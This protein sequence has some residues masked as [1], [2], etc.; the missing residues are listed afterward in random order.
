MRV[1]LICVAAIAHMGLYI[2]S[3]AMGQDDSLMVGEVKVF[4]IPFDIKSILNGSDAVVNGT[5]TLIMTGMAPGRTNLIVLGSKDERI[6]Y[7]I[8]ISVDNR[9][10]VY[11]HEGPSN[12]VIFRCGDRCEREESEEGESSPLDSTLPSNDGNAQPN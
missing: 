2:S 1:W 3:P 12:N 4:Q 5:R 10:L 9:D 11:L 6:D 8:L 7:S